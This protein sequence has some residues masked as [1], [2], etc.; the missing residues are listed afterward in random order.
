MALAAYS[1]SNSRWWWSKSLS[2]LLSHP[3]PLN[4][5][6]SQLN[7]INLRHLLTN[8]DSIQPINPEAII[9]ELKGDA[10]GW[11]SIFNLMH[12][13]N[14]AV[15]AHRLGHMTQPASFYQFQIASFNFIPKF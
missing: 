11:T 14:Y 3:H 12:F 10:F 7:R 1:S 9:D 8:Q 13:F 5:R 2:R 4:H 6:R 15:Y